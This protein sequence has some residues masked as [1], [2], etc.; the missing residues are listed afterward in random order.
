LIKVV[1]KYTPAFLA[2]TRSIIDDP[3]GQEIPKRKLSL[4]YDTRK[5]GLSLRCTRLRELP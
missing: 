3:S 1:H 2:Y 4:P 5:E